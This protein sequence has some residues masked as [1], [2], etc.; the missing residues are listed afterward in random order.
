[1]FK[2]LRKK[3]LKQWKDLLRKKQ[4]PNSIFISPSHIRGLIY[5]KDS[6]LLG[7]LIL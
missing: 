6:V 5:W 1:M 7:Y 4:L 3:L 2:R